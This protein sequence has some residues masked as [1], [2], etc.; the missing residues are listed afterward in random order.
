MSV[1][2]T[3]LIVSTQ[4]NFFVNGIEFKLK[5]AGYKGEFCPAIFDELAMRRDTADLVI[6]YTDEHV[7]EHVKLHA[8]LKDMVA[9]QG[10]QLIV[11]GEKLEYEAMLGAVSQK[12]ILK[13]F[14]RPFDMKKLLEL[15]DA[16]F[17]GETS[18]VDTSQKQILI[19]DDD[20]TYMEM[21]KNWLKDEYLVTLTPSALKALPWLTRK[22]VDLILLDYEMPELSGPE[23]LKQLHE[24][25]VN[26]D[27]PVMFLTGHQDRNS[28]MTAL[29][30]KPAGYMLKTI[31]NKT[32]HKKLGSFF[33]NR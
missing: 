17:S 5:A 9:T 19:I 13:W 8:L 30:Q 6:Y 33:A 21:L 31:D 24:A 15:V 18:A 14:E 32:L 23:F 29:G 2:D 22:R 20:V 11:I 27:I 7:F 16:Y 3:V 1:K 26:N 28:V 25:D 10:K 12:Y 4:E